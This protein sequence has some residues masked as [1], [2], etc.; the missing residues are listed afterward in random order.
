MKSFL[1]QSRPIFTTMLQVRKPEDCFS[2]IERAKTLGTDAFGF[3][4]EQLKREYRTEEVYRDLFENRMGNYPV[5]VTSYN[6]A[7]SEGLTDEECLEELL[8]AL[9]CGGTLG[10]V[11]GDAFDKEAVDQLTFN[12]TAIDKQ[13][14]LIERIRNMGKEV[15][16]STHVWH[17][18]PA[19]RVVEIALAQESRGADIAKVVI[20]TSTAEEE[21]EG[22]RAL[23]LLK[24]ELKIPF[25]FLCGGEHCQAQRMVA[26]YFGNALALCVEGYDE[27]ATKVQPPLETAKRLWEDLYFIKK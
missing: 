23:T 10:D 11:M 14:R 2:S 22:L 8:V 15:L 6:A 19:E 25:L 1:G 5:Y 12:P 3:Q 9:K 17:F 26:P 7:Q 21:A 16:M 18:I 20:L 4:I 27:L 13:K 24:K